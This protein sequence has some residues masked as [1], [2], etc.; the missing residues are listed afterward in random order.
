LSEASRK[1]LEAGADDYIP[2]PYDVAE[3][4][5]KIEKWVVKNNKKSQSHSTP[6]TMQESYQSQN[7]NSLIDLEYLE[8]LS[9][10]DNDFTISML[11]YFIDN[12]PGIISEMK[13]YYQEKDYKALRNVAHKFKPQLTFMGIKSIFQDVENIE[14]YAGTATNTDAIPGL[15]ERTEEVCRKAMVEIKAELEK[16]L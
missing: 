1:C 8:Q 4:K 15:I 10:G 14:Q 9:E 16:M 11:S 6:S 3:L 2:K 5:T 7:D 13:Q 12:T